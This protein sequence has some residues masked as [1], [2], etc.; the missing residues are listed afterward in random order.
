[1][2]M[3]HLVH[4]IFSVVVVVLLLLIVICQFKIAYP[5]SSMTSYNTGYNSG[6]VQ[7]LSSRSDKEG[8]VGSGAM[9]APVFWN[10]GS[11]Q[12]TAAAL[13]T[14]AAQNAADAA[15]HGGVLSDE[16]FYGGTSYNTGYKPFV[17]DSPAAQYGHS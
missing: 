8:F 14:A 2:E 9:E 10:M 13:A 6:Q 12:A 5:S 4:Y 7:Y 15:A 16:S 3:D 11:A 1:M 17:V